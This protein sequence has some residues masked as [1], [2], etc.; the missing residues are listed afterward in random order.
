M[1]DWGKMWSWLSGNWIVVSLKPGC[2]AHFDQ[3]AAISLRWG[4]EGR[5]ENWLYFLAVEICK[6]SFQK[7]WIGN[8]DTPWLSS[9]N[10][11]DYWQGGHNQETVSMHVH[12]FPWSIFDTPGLK[13][14]GGLGLEGFLTFIIS[15]GFGRAH[16]QR[17]PFLPN[18]CVCSVI[19]WASDSR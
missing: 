11:G 14:W 3:V 8:F 4:S 10:V 18:L 13:A 2:Q 16:T 7:W 5:T 15:F 1:I 6:R 9:F 12:Y 17:W 19:D